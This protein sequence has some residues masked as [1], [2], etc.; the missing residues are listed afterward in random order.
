[1]YSVLIDSNWKKHMYSPKIWIMIEYI[2]AYYLQGEAKSNDTGW[3][4][5]NGPVLLSNLLQSTL[6]LF[7]TLYIRV[8]RYLC[9]TLYP[10]YL[11]TSPLTY[12]VFSPDLWSLS[13]RQKQAVFC[14]NET[15]SC[16]LKRRMDKGG[17]GGKTGFQ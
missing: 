13:K 17:G 2:T 12:A 8:D 10:T 9:S 1:M 7:S 11:S 16:F 14:K 4:E 3:I 5:N 15:F 6:P